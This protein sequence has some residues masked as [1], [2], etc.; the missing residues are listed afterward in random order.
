MGADG[1]AQR[2]RL[3]WLKLGD[4][5]KKYFHSKASQQRRRN[6]I[7]GVQNSRGVWV[8]RIEDVAEVAVQ[9]FE[10]LFSSGT[11]DR[12]EDCL[13]A[14]KHR[15]SSDMLNILSEEFSADE[16][17]TVLFQIGPTKAP[18]LNGMNA[19]FYQKFWHIVGTNITNAVLDFLNTGVMLLELNYNHTVLIPKVKSP[20]KMSNFSLISL[21]NVMYKIISKMLANRL[22]LILPQLISPYQSAFVPGRLITDNVLMAYETLHAMH[23]RKKG[24]KGDIALKLDISKANDRVE[25]SFLKGMMFKMGFPQWWIDQIMCCVTTSSFSVHI[26]GKAYGNFKPTRGLRQRDPLSL[27]LFLLCAEAFAS[28]LAKEDEL[29]RLHGVSICQL[30][31]SISHLLFADDSLVFCQA[32][33]E[34]V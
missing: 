19:L 15:L 30:A 5:N 6:F 11:C 22:K 27:Y 29:G 18:G 12:V 17:K 33:Q 24:K 23:G 32:K 20:E 25:W 4:K 8:D 16:V 2:S 13:N 7:Q 34:E 10:N 14:V 31:P 3:S 9:Y 21:C 28:L 1:W 26:N